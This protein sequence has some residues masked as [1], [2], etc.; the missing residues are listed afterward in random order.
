M[1]GNAVAIGLLPFLAFT[2]DLVVLRRDA[3]ALLTQRVPIAFQVIGVLDAGVEPLRLR[4]QVVDILVRGLRL[5]ALGTTANA[6]ETRRL[7]LRIGL[8]AFQIHQFAP[9]LLLGVRR[10]ETS[11]TGIEV[12]Q[13]AFLD[14]FNLLHPVLDL[15]RLRHF[16]RLITGICLLCG[17][18]RCGSGLFVLFALGLRI[19]TDSRLQLALRHAH[20][21]RVVQRRLCRLCCLPLLTKAAIYRLPVIPGTPH[22]V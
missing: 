22:P 4:N 8:V 10:N 11:R 20:R 15:T 7:V 1:L 2:R 18:L 19:S 14:A 12:F 21:R 17:Q 9:C 3:V 16:R 13:L 6:K 5:V